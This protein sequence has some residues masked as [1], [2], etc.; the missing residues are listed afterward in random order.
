MMT[1]GVPCG[2][3]DLHG[4]KYVPMP[5]PEIG[6]MQRVAVRMQRSARQLPEIDTAASAAELISL[7]CHVPPVRIRPDLTPFTMSYAV[8]RDPCIYEGMAVEKLTSILLVLD[9]T[10]ADT[11]LL[12]KTVTLARRTGASDVRR[13]T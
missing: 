9:G 1:V 8:L 11:D 13:R 7:P 10:A 5:A 12:S 3:T 2:H 4:S 6:S